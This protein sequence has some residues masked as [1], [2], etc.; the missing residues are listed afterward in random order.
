M[1]GLLPTTYEKEKIKKTKQVKQESEM[2]N[3]TTR[4]QG[5]WAGKVEKWRCHQWKKG[6]LKW[7]GTNKKSK[8]LNSGH[9]WTQN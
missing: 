9:D 2:G 7:D 6:N 5:K 8:K 3:G 1:S 4:K